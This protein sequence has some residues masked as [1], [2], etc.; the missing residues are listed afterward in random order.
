[1]AAAE[2]LSNTCLDD[3]ATIDEWTTKRIVLKE[4]LAWMLGLRPKPTRT[5]LDARIVATLA[6]PRYLLKRVIFQ[7]QPGLFV[8]SNFYTPRDQSTPVPCVVYLCG[9]WPSVYGAKSGFQDRYLWYPNNGFACLVIDPL[10]FGEIPGVHRGTQGMSLWSWFSLGYT[11]AGVEIWNAMRA[12]DWLETREEVDAKRIG[13]TGISGGGVITQYLAALDDRIAVAAPS[14]SSYT[15]GSQAGMNLVSRQCDCTFYPNVFRLDFPVVAALIAP[16][17]LMIFGGRRDPLFPPAGFREA[18]RRAKRI[19]DLY[20]RSSIGSP[21]IRLVESRSGHED[22]PAFLRECQRWMSLWLQSKPSERTAGNETTR[23]PVEDG[24]TIA[25][26][27]GLPAAAANYHIHETWI[28]SGQSMPP[29]DPAVWAE[30]RRVILGVIKNSICS[31]FP[32]EATPYRTRRLRNSGGH[33]NEF[34]QFAEYEFDSEPN[35]PVRACVLATRRGGD[36]TSLLLWIARPAEQDS[37]PVLDEI[38]PLLRNTCV[39]ILTPR[40]ADDVVGRLEYSRI[41]RLAA[42]TGRT[43][44]SMGVW[45]VLRTIEWARHQVGTPRMSVAVYGGGDAGVIGLYAAHLDPGISHV[46]VREPPTSHRQ[47]SHMLTILRHTDIPEIA[48][49]LAPRRF[50]FVGRAD[51]AFLWTKQIYQLMGAGG[52]FRETRSLAEAVI[53]KAAEDRGER[54]M[55]C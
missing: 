3:V 14:C 42:L 40:F 21:R 43:M 1:M 51:P 55:P 37:V 30:R 9:H 34:A 17:P 49:V 46:I 22:P 12:I 52:R 28:S 7:S 50:S 44:A 2:E 24:R 4:Q 18:F 16:R 29:T 47:G 19:Y 45:D 38:L 5:G 25:C 33:A 39:V 35:V 8:T 53:T 54:L 10:G 11:P 41:E 27:G 13:V 36:S 31:W 6:R 48:G 23:F 32:T 26:L 20:S 15:I